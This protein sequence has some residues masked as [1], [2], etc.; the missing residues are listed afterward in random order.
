MASSGTTC[1][2]TTQLTPRIIISHGCHGSAHQADLIDAVT[3]PHH[4][5][6]RLMANATA[7]ATII[8]AITVTRGNCCGRCLANTLLLQLLLCCHALLLLLLQQVLLVLQ[9]GLHQLPVRI[10]QVAAKH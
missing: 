7:A 8:I 5:P 4:H 3:L 2:A 10:T 9:D 1:T 6:N